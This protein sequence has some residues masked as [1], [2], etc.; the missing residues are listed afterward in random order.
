MRF[1]MVA[2][3][4]EAGEVAVFYHE[5]D[6]KAFAA[7]T[8]QAPAPRPTGIRPCQCG[9]EYAATICPVNSEFCG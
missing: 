2:Y 7:R 9:S 1:W 6:A 8:P 3:G 5:E 4:N